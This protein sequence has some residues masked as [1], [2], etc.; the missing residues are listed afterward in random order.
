MQQ[1]VSAQNQ[2]AHFPKQ[3]ENNTTVEMEMKTAK[4]ISHTKYLFRGSDQE[5]CKN[6][7]VKIGSRTNMSRNSNQYNS[8]IQC[9]KLK[10]MLLSTS[11]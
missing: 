3:N 7:Q 6:E 2:P 11:I 1:H 8:N 5:S 4:Q 10:I 9:S